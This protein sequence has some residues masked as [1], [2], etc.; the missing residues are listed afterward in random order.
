M[1]T[2]LSWGNGFPNLVQMFGLVSIVDVS[3]QY[4]QIMKGFEEIIIWSCMFNGILILYEGFLCGYDLD[5][6]EIILKFVKP[7]HQFIHGCSFLPWVAHM[8]F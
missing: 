6:K 7:L 5:I 8:V 2:I 3:Y 1:K 4:L